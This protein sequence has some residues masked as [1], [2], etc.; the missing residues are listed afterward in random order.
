MEVV[1]LKEV[2]KDL[3]IAL[4]KE[5]GYALD[6]DGVHVVRA[7]SGERA[8]DPYSNQEVRLDNMMIL[9]GSAVLLDDNE[10]S[11]ISYLEDKG[12]IL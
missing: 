1:S 11:L 5:L 2:P 10:F 8:V 7:E 9:P 4:L 12:D 3:K 6:R